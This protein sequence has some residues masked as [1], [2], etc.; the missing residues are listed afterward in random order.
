MAPLPPAPACTYPMDDAGRVDVLQ[1]GQGC[2]CQGPAFPTLPAAASPA[3]PPTFSPRSSWYTRNW[4]CSSLSAWHLTMLFRSAP[5]RVVTRYLGK[6]E[7]AP[8]VPA[9]PSPAARSPKASH[10]AE[11]LDGGGRGEDVQERDDLGK[12]A[13]QA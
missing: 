4:T 12:E 1:H 13:G 9:A 5:I 3:Q 8:A 6:Q 10:F 7:S 11:V 2:Q